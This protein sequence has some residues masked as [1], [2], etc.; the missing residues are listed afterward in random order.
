MR[1]LIW[2][3]LLLAIAVVVGILFQGHGGNVLIIAQPWRIELS[4]SLAI[5]I[6]LLLFLVLHLFLR[7]AGWFYHGPARIRSWRNRRSSKKDTEL[8]ELGWLNKL[9]G[10]YVQSEKDFTNLVARTKSNK[11]KVLALLN[12]AKSLHMLGEVKRRDQI[13]KQAIEASKKSADLKLATAVVHTRMLLDESKVDEAIATITPFA[14]NSNKAVFAN[15]LL[16]RAYL[17]MGDSNK[18]LELTRKLLRSNS[19]DK[20]QA[21]DFIVRAVEQLF[22]VIDETQYK[23]IWGTLKSEEKLDPTIAL[24]AA[25]AQSRFGNAAESAQIMQAV[26]KNNLDENLLHFY[27]HCTTEQAS[28]RMGHAEIWLKSNPDNPALLAALGQLCLVA[29]LWGQAKHY[30]ERSLELRSDV[31][32]YALLGSMHDVLGNPDKALSNWRKACA[33]AEAEIPAIQR[34]LPPADTNDDPRFEDAAIESNDEPVIPE[35]ASAVYYEDTENIGQE[36]KAQGPETQIVSADDNE[37]FDTAPIP[38]VDMSKTT[39][40]SYRK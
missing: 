22:I 4:L 28:K 3:L 5:V 15:R 31:Y 8:I 10:N 36:I 26:L 14:D 35:A 39:D 18:V 33:Q 40:R 16:L 19:I 29:Q 37:Y 6:I 25:Q 7:L 20:K 17:A 21:H 30:L 24:A 27:A 32:I 23:K 12:S 38:G 1:S 34:L 9:Q 2:Y 11:R 13:L